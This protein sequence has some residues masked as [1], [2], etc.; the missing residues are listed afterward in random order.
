MTRSSQTLP[1]TDDPCIQINTVLRPERT[2]APLPG[3]DCCV[4]KRSESVP[5]VVASIN[6]CPMDNW[7]VEWVSYL[8]PIRIFFFNLYFDPVFTGTGWRSPKVSLMSRG[9]SLP[10]IRNI[11]SA[12]CCNTFTD[13]S[14]L[15]DS[16]KHA[17]NWSF[18]HLLALSDPLNLRHSSLL[19]WVLQHVLGVDISKTM[20]QLTPQG[21]ARWQ[22]ISP[23]PL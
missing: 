1:L 23:K 3:I 16:T 15:H 5:L 6:Q 13:L 14:V 21:T 2:S 12:R 10:T 20:Q 17:R 18:P 11:Q 7:R 19:R 4:D 8:K 9:V 22:V